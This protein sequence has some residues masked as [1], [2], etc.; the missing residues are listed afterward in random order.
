MSDSHNIA[1][2]GGGLM[3]AGIAL[4]FASA[5]HKV[6]VY[7]VSAEQLE[8][9]HASVLQNLTM[10]DGDAKCIKLITPEPDFAA[11]V[12]D[13]D[14]VFEAVVEKLEVKRSIFAKLAT[15]APKSAILCSNTSVI[16]ITR[17]AENNPA[18]ERIVGT[19]WWNP[20]F[21]VPLVEVIRA[22]D[23]LDEAV[24]ATISLLD[25]V[26]KVAVRVDKDVPGFVGNRLQHA[27][28]R[29]AISLVEN[30]VCDADT[31]DL[32]VKNSFG[33]RMPVLGP[34]ENADLVGL[35]LTIDIHDN[36]LASLNRDERASPLLREKV[37]K[38]D[39]GF[40]TGKGLRDWTPEKIA[41]V[42][43]GLLNYLLIATK[44]CS[45]LQKMGGK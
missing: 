40:K 21:L 19:H 11:A 8:G 41:N 17:I 25:S 13:A 35:D 31:V 24:E 39:L 14:F 7:D 3:G 16:P 22:Q 34:I 43:M 15:Y 2:I 23:S 29:E 28:W 18:A 1:I 44:K 33:L 20:P 6:K 32:V 12:A 45:I 4:V 38:G 30:G 42:R 9:L 37:E 5:G 27:L 26:G 10:I 36:I